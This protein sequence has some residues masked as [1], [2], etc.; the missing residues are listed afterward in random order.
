MFLAKRGQC[1]EQL[2]RSKKEMMRLSKKSRQSSLLFV[3]LFAVILGASAC[4]KKAPEGLLIDGIL[5]ETLYLRAD[6]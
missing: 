1:M 6:G 3:I 2:Q 5:T 4:S